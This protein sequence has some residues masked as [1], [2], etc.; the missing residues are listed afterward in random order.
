[1]EFSSNGE[2]LEDKTQYGIPYGLSLK[3]YYFEPDYPDS[4]EPNAFVFGG[5]YTSPGCFDGTEVNWETITME[6]GGL[7]LYAKWSP[8]THTVDV[9]LDDTLEE[10]I[11]ATQYVPHGN[12]AQAPTETISNG[13]YIFQGWFYIDA[14]DGTE[15]AFVFTGIPIDQNMKVYAK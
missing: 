10:Q 13:N 15:K 2:V 4:L 5:W 11:G 12:F 7:L 14:E 6:A 9:Y 8:V 3:D 1:L